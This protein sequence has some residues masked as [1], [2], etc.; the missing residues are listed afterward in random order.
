[1][2]INQKNYHSLALQEDET[3]SLS[4]FYQ[5]A[6]Y[7]QNNIQEIRIQAADTSHD[8]LT[9]IE[10]G[11]KQGLN[12]SQNRGASTLLPHHLPGEIIV[13]SQNTTSAVR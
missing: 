10:P 6:D 7:L 3:T 4:V 2:T 1:M 5:I 9:F 8:A 13:E 12:D 11:R